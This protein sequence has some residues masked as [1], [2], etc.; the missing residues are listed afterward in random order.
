MEKEWVTE[1]RDQCADAEVAFFFKQWGGTRK[2]K[3][4]RALDGQFYDEMPV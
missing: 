4:G 2:S 1:I 3:T